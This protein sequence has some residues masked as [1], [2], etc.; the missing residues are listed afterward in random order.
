MEFYF[1][2]CEFG[3]L[4]QAQQVRLSYIFEIRTDCHRKEHEMRNIHKAGRMPLSRTLSRLMTAK[5]SG[6]NFQIIECH[7][8]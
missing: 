8:F 5:K 1:R 4:V 3:Q 6:A 7:A 2:L